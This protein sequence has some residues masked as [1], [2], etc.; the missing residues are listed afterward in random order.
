MTDQELEQRLRAWYRT[1][2]SPDEMAPSA[3]RSSLSTIP[4]ASSAGWRRFLSPRGMAL[5]AAAAVIGLLAGT[6]AV[7]AFLNPRP[8]LIP[9]AW[10]GT[11]AMDDVHYAHI[12]TLLRDGRVLVTGGDGDAPTDSAELFEPASGTW[13]AA[14]NMSNGRSMHT[15]TLLADGRVLVAGGVDGNLSVQSYA[16][17]YDARTD[18]WTATDSMVEA[19]QGHSATLLP[20]GRVLV[21]GG[22]R[23]GHLAAAELYDPATGTWTTTGD[24]LRERAFHTATLLADGRVLVAGSSDEA[25][26]RSAELYDARTGT[27]TATGSMTHG[28]PGFTATLLPDGHVLAAGSESEAKS[29]L[30][31]SRTGSWTATGSMITRRFGNH[32]AALLPDGT[33]LLA[34]G[35]SGNFDTGTQELAA[36]EI[37]DPGRGTWAA[38]AEMTRARR[39]HTATSLP[40][41]RVLVVG[42]ASG[43]DTSRS[44]ELYRA[45]GGGSQDR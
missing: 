38:T 25:V 44:A 24:M 16:E 34:G 4:L 30:Y 7:G 37:Y 23:D 36:A 11:G 20:D 29:E 6:I 9:A 42:G 28:R 19:R 8:P 45:A 40:D 26:A 21:A 18:S 15:A 32:A 39:W 12:A 2:I 5:V 31:D 1:E 17:L 35:S 41:G 14:V 33:V 27:W 10:S 13:S 22:T 3:L 43:N